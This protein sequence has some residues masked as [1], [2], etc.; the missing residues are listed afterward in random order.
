MQQ[1]DRHRAED[2]PD[3]VSL[4]ETVFKADEARV[5][6]YPYYI[7]ECEQAHAEP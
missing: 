4:H 5:V 6:E 3:G 2:M 1:H 7:C